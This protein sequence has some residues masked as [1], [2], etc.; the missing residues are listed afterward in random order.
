VTSMTRTMIS[1]ICAPP[2]I[3]RIKDACPGQST[4]ENC[5]VS[6]PLDARCSGVE[7]FA[8]EKPRSSVIPRSWLCGCLSNPAVE[9]CELNTLAVPLAELNGEIYLD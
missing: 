2:I 6:K 1:I 5:M 4:I 3:V 8:M 9:R 7:N